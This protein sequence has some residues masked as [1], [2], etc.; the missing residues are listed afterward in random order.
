[1][2]A[3]SDAASVLDVTGGSVDGARDVSQS[4]QTRWEVTIDP[5]GAGDVHL[6]VPA[7]ECNETG[8]VCVNG[9][10]LEEDVDAAVPGP[11]GITAELSGAASGH[12]G[13]SAFTLELTF[14]PAPKG[15][16]F[17]TVE[18]GLF[19][20][21][22]GAITA[23]RRA[24]RGQNRGWELTVAPDGDGEVRLT[25]RATTDCAARTRCATPREGS[26]QAA[27]WL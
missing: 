27:S 10:A 7:R 5:D 12:D 15:L 22:G 19:D 3:K 9:Q 26:S 2:R 18:G 23:V 17:R 13:S 14:R 21:T 8:A 24:T 16:S 4:G 6:R 25:A 11:G 20:V 1:M